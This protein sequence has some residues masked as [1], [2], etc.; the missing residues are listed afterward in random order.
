MLIVKFFFL[1]YNLILSIGI[2]CLFNHL[3]N[4][5]KILFNNYIFSVGTESISYKI[6]YYI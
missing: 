1:N 5:F 2:K 4:S 6:V 3:L